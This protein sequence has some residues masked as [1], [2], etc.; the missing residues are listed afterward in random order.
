MH[1]RGTR[2][3]VPGLLA[4]L[5]AASVPS[6]AAA[7]PIAGLVVEE[8]SSLP[9]AGAMVMLFDDGG[10]RIDRMLTNAAGGF[11][12]TPRQPG[13]HYITVERIGYANLTTDLF[14]P[15][16][17]Q[18]LMTVEVPVEPVELSGLDVSPGQRCEVRPEEGRVVAQ[19]W[20]EVRKA[21]SAEAWTREA[22]LYRYTLLRFERMLDRDAEGVISDLSQLA[23]DHDAAFVSVAIETL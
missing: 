20:E 9:V 1:F 6:P 12:L 2:P 7:Q 14:E 16:S 3:F 15:A 17:R 5:L 13:P 8:G 4:G 19:V 21:L 18:D 23:E 10:N 22:G 11:T